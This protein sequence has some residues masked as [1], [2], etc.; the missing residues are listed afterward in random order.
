MSRRIEVEKSINFTD[1]V[2]GVLI[3]ANVLINGLMCAS[4][5]HGWY[6]QSLKSLISKLKINHLKFY[7]TEIDKGIVAIYLLV[8]VQTL[9]KHVSCDDYELID[10][11]LKSTQTCPVNSSVIDCASNIESVHPP[12]AL[13]LAAAFEHDLVL[14]TWEPKHF[15]GSPLEINELEVQQYTKRHIGNPEDVEGQNYQTSEAPVPEAGVWIFSVPSF[16]MM[17]ENPMLDSFGLLKTNVKSTFSFKDY[18][19][20]SSK[21]CSIC[22]IILEI[23]GNEITADGTDSG[24]VDAFLRAIENAVNRY[25]DFPDYELIFSVLDKWEA[26]PNVDVQ[27][28]CRIGDKF[29]RNIQKSSNLGNAIGHAYINV[30]NAIIESLDLSI[31]SD[32]VNSSSS[33][34]PK[35]FPID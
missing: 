30:L 34:L 23:D 12:D 9:S 24:L 3:S 31:K 15:T 20:S 7:L 26:S 4:K 11:F 18:K 22:S 21:D 17:L 13:R 10:S 33:T 28:C 2:R 16:S 8:Y 27:I 5:G 29:Y 1:E 19:L 6:I 25:F 14:V 32:S 35:A